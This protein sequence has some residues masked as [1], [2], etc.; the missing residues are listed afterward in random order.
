MDES[1]LHYV[2]EKL[3]SML[4]DHTRFKEEHKKGIKVLVDNLGIIWD[5]TISPKFKEINE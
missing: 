5:I 1:E 2:G 3:Y 4:K